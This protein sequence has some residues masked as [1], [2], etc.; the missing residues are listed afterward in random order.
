MAEGVIRNAG[1]D[2][3]RGTERLA[4]FCRVATDNVDEAA[5]E[6]G[7]IFCPHDLKPLRTSEPGFFA[8]HN[9]AAFDGFSINY[10]AY[11][12]SVSI[13]PGCL[14][15]FF[16]MQLPLRGSALVSTSSR[17][18][19]TTPGSTASVLSP[20]LPTRMAWKNDCAQLILL[21][22]R[23]LVEQ[24]AAALA[25][26]A[27]QTIEFD[28]VV[29]LKAPAAQALQAQM[30]GL[31]NLA[32]GLR[33]KRNLSPAAAANWREGILDRLLTGQPHG[34][35]QAIKTFAGE[36]ETLPQALRR[37]RDYL[38]AHAADPF[39]L[40]QLATAAGIGIRALQL[41]FQRH[42][43]MSISQMLLDLRLAHLNTRLKAAP[44][45]A[46]IIDIAFD[47]GFTHVSRMAGAY[48][49]KFGETPSATLRRLH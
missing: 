44:P 34:L 17:D 40:V 27:V 24:R 49:Q 18:I 16:L 2:R 23:K 36:G 25:G 20:T 1:L 28:P 31:V 26:K 39:D 9:C 32:E 21:V 13:D 41:G 14:E 29:D 45:D 5:E 48:R 4:G 47:L 42:F 12:G 6:I 30:L 35:S 37:A 15:R 11:G 46:R 19:A 10:V 7:R 33:P 3:P 38:V 22:E 43:G 8:R